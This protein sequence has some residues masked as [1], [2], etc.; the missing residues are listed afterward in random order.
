[1]NHCFLWINLDW[2]P[3]NASDILRFFQKKRDSRTHEAPP[4]LK[5]ATF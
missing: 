3:E 5:K 1:M 2:F 4:D